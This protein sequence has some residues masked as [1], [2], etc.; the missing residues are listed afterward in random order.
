[1]RFVGLVIVVGVVGCEPAVR[2]RPL[3]ALVVDDGPQ[4]IVVPVLELAA[5]ESMAWNVAANG[6]TIARAELTVGDGWASS[7]IRTSELAA[8][9]ATVS[10][11]LMT[12]FAADR[13]RAA[14]EQ[15][16]VN[17][18]TERMTARFA[19]S[20]VTLDDRAVA[21]P[22]GLPAHTL[23]SALGALRAWSEFASGPGFLYVAHDNQLYLLTVARPHHSTLLD[24]RV[25][26]V[27]GKIT[28]VGSQ[29]ERDP[30]AVT[31]WLREGD[32]IPLRITARGPNGAVTATLIDRQ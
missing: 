28:M 10:Y 26:E 9:F 17:G 11:D 13:A 5:G 3:P 31:L 2:P 7:R 15:L 22:G 8:A 14:T 20:T 30:I 21:V 24:R 4:P 29:R 1:M 23:H 6:F 16:V 12:E 18:A 27:A 19:G 32:R 25:I